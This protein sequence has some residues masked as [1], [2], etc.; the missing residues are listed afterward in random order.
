MPSTARDPLNVPSGLNSSAYT[1][2]G[3]SPTPEIT[4]TQKWQTN[5]SLIQRLAG[6]RCTLM[7][8]VW[9]DDLVISDRIILTEAILNWDLDAGEGAS[10]AVRNSRGTFKDA[11]YLFSNP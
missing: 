5:E 4:F 2:V 7:V 10:P 11:L 9:K 3:P 1:V 8:E 6:N